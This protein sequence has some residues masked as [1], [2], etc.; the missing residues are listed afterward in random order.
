MWQESNWK[1]PRGVLQRNTALQW[2]RNNLKADVA[3]GVIYFADDDNSYGL[4]VFEEVRL[5]SN[6]LF[7]TSLIFH[8][9]IYMFDILHKSSVSTIELH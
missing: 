2:I 4:E 1:K 9:F 5:T 3:Q 8:I 7:V 6:I